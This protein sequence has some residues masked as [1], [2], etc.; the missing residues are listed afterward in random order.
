MAPFSL[1][2]E[3]KHFNTGKSDHINIPNIDKN[4]YNLRIPPTA[5]T[6]GDH[7]VSVKK[8]RDA[9]GCTRRIPDGPTVRVAVAD[10]PTIHPGD[11]DDFCVGDRIA[12]TLAGVPPFAV[13]YQ[14][15][16]ALM[17]A[18]NQPS[19]FV[20][21]AEKAGN[22]TI[23]GLQDSASDCKVDVA[24]TKIVHEVP[25][26]KISE[27]TAVVKGIPEGNCIYLQDEILFPRSLVC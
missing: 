3:I 12:F 5:L 15:N 21:V 16:G 7:A 17:K 14:W 2:I 10:L 13:E 19:Q 4:P 9:R 18:T 22:F 11:K 20:R 1:T 23:T 27:G 25:S 24:Y 26:V 6:L 8:V